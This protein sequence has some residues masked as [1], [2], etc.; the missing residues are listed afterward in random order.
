[1]HDGTFLNAF[2]W[3][4]QAQTRTFFTMTLI[5]FSLLFQLS[6]LFEASLLFQ[7]L[8]LACFQGIPCLFQRFSFLLQDFIGLAEKR[9][10]G[11]T[12]QAQP[13]YE[14]M[15]PPL[16]GHTL[17]AEPRPQPQVKLWSLTAAHVWNSPY[18]AFKCPLNSL[19]DGLEPSQCKA[20]I[21]ARQAA[22]LR[23]DYPEREAIL[24]EEKALCRGGEA[25]WEAL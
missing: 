19:P 22:Q 23:R 21:A 9:R 8:L 20:K 2:S 24:K 12:L 6:F 15:P 11:A 14:C 7:G 17:C 18:N 25:I 10:S 5:L 16:Q 3:P 4:V 1:M 13:R